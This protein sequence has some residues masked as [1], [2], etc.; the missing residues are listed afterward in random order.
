MSVES[1]QLGFSRCA[2]HATMGESPHGRGRA[3][4]TQAHWGPSAPPPNGRR[5]MGEDAFTQQLD[6]SRSSVPV[7]YTHLRAHETSAHL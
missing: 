6:A 3:H 5:T 4:F 7:S 2:G 1:V